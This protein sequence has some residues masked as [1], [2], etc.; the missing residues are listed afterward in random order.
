VTRPGETSGT[1]KKGARAGGR[2]SDER[3]EAGGKVAVAY[4]RVSTKEQAGRGGEAE[5]FSIP[6]QRLSIER[7]AEDLGASIVAEF[8]DAGE[9]A[10]SKDRVPAGRPAN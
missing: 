6:A 4:L 8:V 9:S 7:K 3:H 10:R 2:G 1:R 5:G